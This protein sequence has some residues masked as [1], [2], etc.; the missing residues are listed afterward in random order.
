MKAGT[1]GRQ[2]AIAEFFWFANR[3]GHL[4]PQK[5]SNQIPIF[6]V[7]L[8]CHSNWDSIFCMHGSRCCCVTVPLKFASKGTKRTH[9]NDTP[10]QENSHPPN[11]I[12]KQQK[13]TMCK[14]L[15]NETPKKSMDLVEVSSDKNNFSTIR[16][17]QESDLS[18]ESSVSTTYSTISE[19]DAMREGLGF[20][21]FVEKNGAVGV[22]SSALQSLLGLAAVAI[23]DFAFWTISWPVTLK[24][25]G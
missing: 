24:S 5:S 17:P 11:K 10:T 19:D 25:F 4:G 13:P 1:S 16:K 22:A 2:S 15:E 21:T 7:H 20:I 9:K 8:L 6:G 18:D 14:Q 3:V 23:W 12:T